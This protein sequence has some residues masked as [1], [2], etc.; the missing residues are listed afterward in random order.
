MSSGS[1]E[2]AEV[3]G[4]RFAV[5]GPVVWF[6]AGLVEAGVR[7]WVVAGRDGG[8]TVGQVIVGRGQCLSFPSDPRELPLLVREAAER[9]IPPPFHGAA[10]RLLDSLP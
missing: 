10:K 3:V 5:N 9:E 6:R 2:L 1:P 7:T 8:E 4:I